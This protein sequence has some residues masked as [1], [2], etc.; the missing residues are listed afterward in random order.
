MANSWYLKPYFLVSLVLVVT[1]LLLVEFSTREDV[2]LLAKQNL[3]LQNKILQSEKRMSNAINELETSMKSQL[4]RYSVLNKPEDG[5]T[6]GQLQENVWRT[7][8]A[9][10]VLLFLSLCPPWTRCRQLYNPVLAHLISA[11]YRSLIHDW[12]Y[13]LF[14]HK[15][16]RTV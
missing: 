12:L 16:G 9:F 5:Q 2:S 8:N 13:L 6:P 3:A 1:F 4:R 10:E 14:V 15:A 7:V 11:T